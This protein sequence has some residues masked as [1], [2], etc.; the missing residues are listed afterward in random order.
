MSLLTASHYAPTSQDAR[1]FL[2]DWR[3]EILL[4]WR[5]WWHGRRGW[6]SPDHFF[7]ASRLRNDDVSPPPWK[8]GSLNPRGRRSRREAGLPLRLEGRRAALEWGRLP[9][10]WQIGATLLTNG[11]RTGSRCVSGLNETETKSRFFCLISPF[12]PGNAISGHLNTRGD[13]RSFQERA[14][15]FRD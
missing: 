9:R 5:G 10:R 12:P 7:V 14:R 2:A 8:C 1:E 13:S 11:E 4:V 3:R 15:W 6:Q